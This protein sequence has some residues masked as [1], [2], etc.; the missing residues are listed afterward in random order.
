MKKIEDNFNAELIALLP[1]LRIQALALTRNGAAA[2]DLVQT[3]V[4]N[5]L[6]ARGSFTRGTNFPAWMH[7]ILRNR[8]ISDTRKR[9][10]YTDMDDVPEA[11][12]AVPAAHED[13]LVLKELHVALGR[14]PPLQRET[15]FLVVLH[16][17]S[18]EQAAE[19]TGCAT[20][21]AKSRVFRAR[22]QLQLWLA[23]TTAPAATATQMQHGLETAATPTHLF[24]DDDAS[25]AGRR[26]GIPHPRLVGLTRMPGDA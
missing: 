15:L 7:R 1:R 4:A 24:A 11:A 8:F 23:G 14:L 10:P 17:M 6:A 13:S 9:R 3:A 2:D 19:A 18:Y 12:L 21:T 16:G 5:A 22:Q 26:H 20:G 25:A